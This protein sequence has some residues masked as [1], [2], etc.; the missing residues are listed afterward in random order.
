MKSK[1]RT[2]MMNITGALFDHTPSTGLIRAKFSQS[3]I[4]VVVAPVGPSQPPSLRSPNRRS[5]MVARLSHYPSS[6]V[7]TASANHQDAEE[8]GWTT[9]GNSRTPMA[10]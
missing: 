6:K 1:I 5:S 4:R 3:R 2:V 8:A 9:T 7:S 10:L